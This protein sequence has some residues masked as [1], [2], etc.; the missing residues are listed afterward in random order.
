MIIK[1]IRI[2]NF[3]NFTSL[4]SDFTPGANIFFGDNGSGKTNFLESVFVLCL[5]RSQL[6]AADTI[7]MKQ[8]ADYYRLEGTIER[9]E[10]SRA[11][12]VAYQKGYRKKITVDGVT[13]RP[14]ELFENF[15]AVSTGPEDS[16]ILSGPPS[17]RRTFLDMYLSQLSPRYLS[18]LTDYH[19]VLVQKNAALKNEMDPSPFEPLLISHGARVMTHRIQFLNALRERAVA[20]YGEVSR[21]EDFDLKYQP[22]VNL[23]EEN[24]FSLREIERAFQNTLDE[25]YDK[26][27]YLKSAIVGP[28]RDDIFFETAGLPTRQFGSQGQWRTAAIALKLGVYHLLKDKRGAA[29]ILLLDEIFAELDNKRRDHLIKS[30]GEF[31]QLFLTTASE[32]PPQLLT[33]G[34]CYKIA[35]GVL[36]DVS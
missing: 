6:G 24:G 33:N 2:D 20:Y 3:R 22:S 14:A 7:L 12:A 31:S 30:F 15:C 23:P 21:G 28:H 26:E 16:V 19:R 13:V 1:N 17:S 9:D 32:P 11:V 4:E 27:A 35:N 5:G 36:E 29:P 10:R 34:R 8:D 18:E 25:H